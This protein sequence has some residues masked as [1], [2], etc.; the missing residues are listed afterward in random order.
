MEDNE[1]NNAKKNQPSTDANVNPTGGIKQAAKKKARDF[2][3]GIKEAAS[4]GLKA[5]W[6]VLPMQVKIVVIVIIV[7]LVLIMALLLMGMMSESTNTVTNSVS[8]Y[9]DSAEVDEDAKK[10]YDDKKSLLKLKITDINA[11]YKKFLED[12]LGGF[13]T[14]NA[15]QYELGTKELSEEEKEKRIVNIDDKLPTYKHILMTEKYN[16]NLIKWKK[17]THGESSGRDLKDSEIQENKELGLKFP[18][19]SENTKIDKFIEM[20]APYLQTWYIPLAMN[21]A[22]IVNGTEEDSNRNPQFSYNIIKEAYSNVVVNWYEL[23]EAKV[24][25]RYE[26]YR[27]YIQHDVINEFKITE[28]KDNNGNTNAMIN[29]ESIICNTELEDYK[30]IDTSTDTGLA[31]GKKNPMKEEFVSKNVT[32]K[33]AY[34]MEK[35]ET[36]DL[37]IINSFNYQVYLDSDVDARINADSEIPVSEGF[38]KSPENE[39]NKGSSLLQVAS[40]RSFSSKEAILSYGPLAQAKITAKGSVAQATS[41]GQTTT[42]TYRVELP[43]YITYDREILHTVT[44]VW[45][46]KLS[47][48]GS[49]SKKYTI[50]DLVA[51]NESDDRKEKVSATELCGEGYVGYFGSGSGNVNS[52]PATEIKINGKTY[53]V[54][55]QGNYGS[56]SHGGSSIATAGCGL[57]SI[58]TVIGGLTGQKV[59]PVSVGNKTGWSGA[60]F[61]AQYASDLKQY[62]NIDN[63]YRA[64]GSGMP[65]QSDTSLAQKKQI[66]KT[67]IDANLKSGNPVIIQVKGE[68]ASNF[69]TT[70]AHYIVLLGYEN[71]KVIIAN[72]VA[73]INRQEADLDTILSVMYDQ[74]VSD[75]GYILIKGDKKNNSSSNAIIEGATVG[76]DA[77]TNT[78]TAGNQPSSEN[79]EVSKKMQ[80]MIDFAV[81]LEGKIRY[82]TPPTIPNTKEGLKNISQTDCSGFVSSLYNIFFGVNIGKYN[83]TDLIATAPQINEKGL[84]GKSFTYDKSK[85]ASQLQVGDVLHNPGHVTMYIGE[86][87]GVASLI[88][89]GQQGDPCIRPLSDYNNKIDSYARYV[90]S[91][92]VLGTSDSSGL[93]G[94]TCNTEAGNYYRDIQNTDGLNRIDFMNS[95]P[96]IY[97]RYL[98]DGAPYMDYVG[99]ARS[100][101]NLSYWQLKELFQKVYDEK[102]T[103][104]WVYGATLGFENTFLNNKNGVGNASGEGLNAMA[105]EAIKLAQMNNNTGVWHYCWGAADGFHHSNARFLFSTLDEMN[106]YI[107]IGSSAGLDCSAFV[108]SMYKAYTGV[109]IDPWRSRSI[110]G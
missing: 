25:T 14:M 41:N 13:E 47:Q 39:Q 79:A 17:Y 48:T 31:G 38:T 44:R 110:N 85:G 90:N 5:L 32:T 68:I 19:D 96:E 80:E 75:H 86:Y 72:S 8:N 62:Y 12:D 109:D 21:T 77:A 52:T 2:I 45:R 46:D 9:L 88:S 97:K 1:Q 6:S 74:A 59:D 108:E 30:D 89:Q 57:C 65:N 103:L 91:T 63:T 98:R 20:T 84:K 56:T 33:T 26:T 71:G 4:R 3:D 106:K 49:E 70:S 55:S 102:E 105:E 51:Y 93:S 69:G 82:G 81:S 66:S 87:N 34:Y 99:Y 7:I 23:Q 24:V 67:E 29:S 11:M 18:K 36:F 104:P 22:Q 94:G 10:M 107:E 64:W 61:I 15:M 43:S 50:D 78:T 76:A 53:P 37:K 92:T 16:F 54:F 101:L 83:I 42:Y 73:G 27:K 95:N 100:K 58:T 40:P 60:K 35:A 28:Y